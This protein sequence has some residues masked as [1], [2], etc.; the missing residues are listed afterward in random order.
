MSTSIYIGLSGRRIHDRYECLP[1]DRIMATATRNAAA[2]TLKALH[3]PGQPLTL[4]N[5][6]DSLTARTVA[7]LA[8]CKALASASYAVVRANETA[9]D[10][11]TLDIQLPA[12]RGM[13]AVAKEFNKPLSID[14]QDAYGPLLEEAITAC[15][16]LGVSG[17]NLEDVDKESQK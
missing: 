15:V 8:S 6:Y 1:H 13:A 5:V 7:E 16:N 2:A 14:L 17:I 4:A 11:M 10:D 3:K 9:D 12:I